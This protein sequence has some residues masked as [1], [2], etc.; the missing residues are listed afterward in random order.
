M[1][2]ERCKQIIGARNGVTVSCLSFLRW[3]QRVREIQ[4]YK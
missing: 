2:S 3:Q 1:E 4:A